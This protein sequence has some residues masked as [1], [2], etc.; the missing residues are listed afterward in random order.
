LLFILVVS[1]VTSLARGFVKE[2]AGLVA[3]LLAILLGMWFHGSIGAFFLP[4]VSAPQIADL[5]GFGVIF[6]GITAVG[7]VVG[8]VIA[9]ALSVAGLSLFD[10]LLGGAFGLLKGALM[11]A[12][13]VFALLAFSPKG[14]PEAVSRSMVAPYVTWTADV[15]AAIAPRGVRDS[16]ERNASVLRQLWDQGSHLLPKLPDAGSQ[17]AQPPSTTPKPKPQPRAGHQPRPFQQPGAGQPSPQPARA[18][19]GVIHPLKDA[20]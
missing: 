7:G 9:K 5:L 18:L 15:L 3:L 8:L 13:L 1:L 11:G 19:D 16:V 17:P 2:I 6:F 12:I 20:C 10:R 4:Y 14:P